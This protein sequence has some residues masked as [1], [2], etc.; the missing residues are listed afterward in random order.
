[1]SKRISRFGVGPSFTLLSL[2]YAALLVAL[3]LRYP[4]RFR[5]DFIPYWVLAMAGALL[6]VV[7]LF[8]YLVGLVHMTRAYNADALCTDGAFGVCRHP[9]YGAWIAFLAPGAAL[10]LNS[11]IGLT[12]PVVM[13][14]LARVLVRKEERYLEVQ[15]GDAY[16]A[17]RRRVPAFAPLGWL[18]R[19]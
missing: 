5:I 17:Y 9:I 18:R 16:R 12:V 15:F 6:V 10:L 13:Y 8:L 14:A 2:A 7:G 4:A 1:M 11:S 3:W 19:T